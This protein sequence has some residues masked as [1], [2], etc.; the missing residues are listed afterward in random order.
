MADVVGI[1]ISEIVRKKIKR[2]SEKY[3]VDKAFGNK[4]KY[5][6]LGD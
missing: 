4:A 6:E 2:N 3:P 1:D 5:A